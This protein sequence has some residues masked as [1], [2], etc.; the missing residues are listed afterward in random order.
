MNHQPILILLFGH[1]QQLLET[2]QWVLQSRGYRV[3][4]AS[5]LS[6][7]SEIS[8]AKPASLL[9]LCHPL[10]P[11]ERDAAVALAT[12]RWPGIRHRTLAP[13]SG[14]APTGI[15][16]TLLHT[17]DGSSSLISIV[18]QSIQT[19]PEHGGARAS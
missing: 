18:Q 12:A 6:G 15:L 10:R 17:M 1:D 3:L 4:T 13:E 5:S 19:K 14:R 8:R 11:G 9:L 2:R 16:G 7:L